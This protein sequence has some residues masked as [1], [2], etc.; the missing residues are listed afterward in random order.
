MLAAGREEEER[1]EG[2]SVCVPGEGEGVC[3]G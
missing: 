2:E 1:E 3:L